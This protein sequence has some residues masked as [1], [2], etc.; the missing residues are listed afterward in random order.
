MEA[1]H[2]GLH[3]GR[4]AHGGGGGGGTTKDRRAQILSADFISTSLTSVPVAEAVAASAGVAVTV[5]GGFFDFKQRQTH[6]HTAQSSEMTPL[7]INVRTG[8]A[9]FTACSCC[10]CC[11]CCNEDELEEKS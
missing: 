9:D 6:P 5:S 1:R 7:T 8:V 2:Q 4:R 3:P 10:L 11:L